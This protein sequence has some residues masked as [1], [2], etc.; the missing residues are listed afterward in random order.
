MA[1]PKKNSQKPKTSE[2]TAS[3]CAETIVKTT[4]P[5]ENDELWAAIVD[6]LLHDEA[7]M[8]TLIDT[9]S[10]ALVSKLHANKDCMATLADKLL[11]NGTLDRIS[12]MI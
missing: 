9:V 8:Q 12:L 5:K 4:V 10:Q 11:S 1:N 3:A 2:N 7:V 6:M